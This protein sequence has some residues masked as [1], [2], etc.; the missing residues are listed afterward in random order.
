MDYDDDDTA[1]YPPAN[2]YDNDHTMVDD[3]TDD[4]K[5]NC[6]TNCAAIDDDTTNNKTD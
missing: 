4:N 2:D 1:M 5:I 6:L 3:T